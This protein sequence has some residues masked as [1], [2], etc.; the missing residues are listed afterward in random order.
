MLDESWRS[1][2]PTWAPHT[3]SPGGTSRYPHY[4]FGS[5]AGFTA[6]W[7]TYLQAVAIAPLEVEASLLA[8]STRSATWG[9]GALRLVNTDG[10]LTPGG[11]V[12]G[13]LAMA[14]FS[15]INLGG[16]RWLSD[17]NTGIVIWKLFVPI[18]TIVTL[19]VVQLPPGQLHG[20]RRVRPLRLPR[21]LRRSAGRRGVRAAGLRAGAPRW[22]ASP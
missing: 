8:T 17:S 7:T 3:R 19:L 15:F 6:G 10:T 21:D 14:L 18:L 16:A 2:T 1:S 5:F 4:A 20:E 11:I 12:I 22:R 13:I 9:R